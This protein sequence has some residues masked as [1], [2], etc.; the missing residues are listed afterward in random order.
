MDLMKLW[1]QENHWDEENLSYDTLRGVVRAAWDAITEEQLQ[2]LASSLSGNV[3]IE[4]GSETGLREC[5]C[6]HFRASH[7]FGGIELL[8]RDSGIV[9]WSRFGPAAG[10]MSRIQAFVMRG[11]TTIKW[12][13][14]D[15]MFRQSGLKRRRAMKPWG[16]SRLAKCLPFHMNSHYF[17]GL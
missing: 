10:Q 15:T 17:H 13:F 6:G 7:W 1:I 12:I 16:G 8:H 4:G 11:E 14:R 5:T 9:V 3:K 2:E